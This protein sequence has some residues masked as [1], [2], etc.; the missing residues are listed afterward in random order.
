MI[1]ERLLPRALT[2]IEPSYGS[3]VYGD[4]T[5][6]S[7][8]AGVAITGRIDPI[9]SVEATDETRDLTASRYLLL[10]NTTGLTS[11]ARIVDGTTTYE[12]DGLPAV[13]DTPN[14]PH[15][16]EAHLRLVGG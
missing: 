3:D 15:H 2:W 7:W 10:T 4:S 5:V 14:G 12:V 1:P 8:G 13:I 16:T 6:E 11:R 9:T